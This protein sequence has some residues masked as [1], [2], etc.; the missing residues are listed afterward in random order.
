MYDATLFDVMLI[1][2][3]ASLLSSLAFVAMAT[4]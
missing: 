2:M 4:F 3:L 1:G